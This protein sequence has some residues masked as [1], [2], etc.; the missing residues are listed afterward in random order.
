[1]RELQYENQLRSIFN[2]VND[3]LKFAEAKNFGLLTISAAFIFGLTQINFSEDSKV[4]SAAYS[5]FIPFAVLSILVC[6]ISLFPILTTVTRLEWAKSWINR[7]SNFIDEEKKFEN[8][9][10]YGYLKDIDEETFERQFLQKINITQ[11]FTVYEKELI[12]QIIYN[13]RI[14]WLKYQLF[15]IAAFIFSLG[16]IASLILYMIL[17]VISRF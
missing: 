13:S 15:K 6:F 10:F 3:W 11:P 4:G 8:I 5:V 16:L 1:M 2:N 9:H 7:F 12:S 17:L 14:A